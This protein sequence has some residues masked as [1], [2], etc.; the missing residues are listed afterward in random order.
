MIT[1]IGIEGRPLAD[2][3]IWKLN[4]QLRFKAPTKKYHQTKGSKPTKNSEVDQDRGLVPMFVKS[5]FCIC[6]FM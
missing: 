3:A 4:Q 2:K 1:H 6:I 5:T